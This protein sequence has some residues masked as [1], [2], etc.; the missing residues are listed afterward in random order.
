LA[1]AGIAILSI[2]GQPSLECSLGRLLEVAMK[3]VRLH[4]DA[5]SCRQL[6]MYMQGPTIF[7]L[8]FLAVTTRTLRIIGRYTC[9]NYTQ[10]GVSTSVL[11]RDCKML[12]LLLDSGVTAC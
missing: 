2:N 12:K 11:P 3:L 10:L 5:T 1:G 4:Y 7:P 9:R 6:L 8:L